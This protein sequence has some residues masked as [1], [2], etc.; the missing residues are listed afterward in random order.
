MQDRSERLY[1]GGGLSFQV[2]KR[3]GYGTDCRK[4][5]LLC[6]TT[7]VQGAGQLCRMVEY[8]MGFERNEDRRKRAQGSRTEGATQFSDWGSVDPWTTWSFQGSK[9][10]PALT[11][12]TAQSVIGL[13][14]ANSVQ[15][16]HAHQ[17]THD[18]LAVN[19]KTV[20]GTKEPLVDS[21]RGCPG[22][23]VIW[24]FSRRALKDCRR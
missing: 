16:G 14:W 21:T 7:R 11:S 23:D 17:N 18:T 20:Q 19:R 5:T 6:S 9:V 8:C 24:S 15:G 2:E 22:S 3:R 10:C 13:D 12:G 4:G 1:Y